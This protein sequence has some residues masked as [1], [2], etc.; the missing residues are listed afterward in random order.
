[1][2][3]L[4]KYIENLFYSVNRNCL[5]YSTNNPLILC[6]DITTKY[7][8]NKRLI[9]GYHY[10]NTLTNDVNKKYSSDLGVHSLFR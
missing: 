7:R 3:P 10:K 4:I 9:T 2:R 1:M 8:L 5:Q 6:S